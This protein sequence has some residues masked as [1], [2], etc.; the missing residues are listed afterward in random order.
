MVFLLYFS[1]LVDSVNLK[2]KRRAWP[3]PMDSILKLVRISYKIV[4]KGIPIVYI[5]TNGDWN[6]IW[7]TNFD[8]SIL[9]YTIK[10][11]ENVWLVMPI[12]EKKKETKI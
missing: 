12:K 8:Q 7:A 1:K 2:K 3:F 4:K 5:Q 10:H 6:S 9:F 11:I